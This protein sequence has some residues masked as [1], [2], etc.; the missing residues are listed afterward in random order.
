MASKAQLDYNKNSFLKPLGYQVPGFFTDLRFAGEKEKPGPESTVERVKR[1]LFTGLYET[2]K[3]IKLDSNHQLPWEYDKDGKLFSTET[4]KM[5]AKIKFLNK[6]IGIDDNNLWKV[7]PSPLRLIT[8]DSDIR[9]ALMTGAANTLF[10]LLAEREIINA[11]SKFRSNLMK[12]MIGEGKNNEYERCWWID[13]KPRDKNTE[14]VDMPDGKEKDEFM[15]ERKKLLNANPSLTRGIIES[16]DLLPV[17]TRAFLE[18]LYRH[19]PETDEE[20]YLWYKYLIRQ[21]PIT[22]DYVHEEYYWLKLKKALGYDP[23]KNPPGGGPPRPPP[24]PPRGPPGGGPPDDPPPPKDDPNVNDA[25]PKPKLDLELAKIK[26]ENEE[27]VKALEEQK[28]KSSS[29]E[30]QIKQHKIEYDKLRQ[31]LLNAKDDTQRGELMNQELFKQ[32]EQSKQEIVSLTKNL[33]DFKANHFQIVSTLNKQ[34]SFLKQDNEELKRQLNDS[35]NNI[36]RLNGIITKMTNE[37]EKKDQE[38]AMTTKQAESER[39]QLLEKITKLEQ[40]MMKMKEDQDRVIQVAMEALQIDLA[41]K[42]A[43]IKQLSEAYNTMAAETQQAKAMAQMIGTA[44]GQATTEAQQAKE[45]A[46]L[47]G[48]AYGNVVAE[49][50]QAREISK[51]LE[52]TFN[53][54]LNEVEIMRIQRENAMVSKYNDLQEQ[55]RKNFELKDEN[56]EPIFGGDE[57]KKKESKDIAKYVANVTEQVIAKMGQKVGGEKGLFVQFTPEDEE[58]YENEM[59]KLC[60]DEDD[61]DDGIPSSKEF[62]LPDDNS[63]LGNYYSNIMLYTQPLITAYNILSSSDEEIMNEINE[64]PVHSGWKAKLKIDLANLSDEEKLVIDQVSPLAVMLV[65]DYGVG[66]EPMG[67]LFQYN[68]DGIV[69][70]MNKLVDIISQHKDPEYAKNLRDVN[71]RALK[72]LQENHNNIM[73]QQEFKK[74]LEVGFEDK[75]LGVLQRSK[76]IEEIK[77]VIRSMSKPARKNGVTKQEVNIVWNR[78]ARRVL[79]RDV[80]KSVKINWKQGNK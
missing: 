79:S 68:P 47:I 70:T 35:T 45:A 78:V 54:K 63:V 34:T 19:A 28:N 53:Q 21:E 48:T 4:D 30:N 20:F 62:P 7:V 56:K 3:G 60:G 41:N 23:N 25:P 73:R 43:Q 39:L 57:D 16:S 69:R 2:A 37:L 11:E 77:K 52:N 44:Y 49:L 75:I 12:W 26:K 55:I 27:T 74:S 29:L 59:R 22:Y 36:T 1:K 80:F 24:P 67:N 50:Q 72:Y 9:R 15:E 18:H 33:N 46:Q 58:M 31:S 51:M 42:S 64:N 8:D 61:E 66:E 40:A 5:D 71:T 14:V 6:L 17:R 76:S 38:I 65:S 10:P 32:V 13:K